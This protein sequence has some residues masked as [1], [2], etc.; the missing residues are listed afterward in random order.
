MYIYSYFLSFTIL[1]SLLLILSRHPGGHGISFLRKHPHGFLR[2]CV[3]VEALHGFIQIFGA[4]VSKSGRLTVH[5]LESE[6]VKI[7][8]LPLTY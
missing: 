3:H 5:L 4:R 6:S 7:L 1:Y 2:L 8:A